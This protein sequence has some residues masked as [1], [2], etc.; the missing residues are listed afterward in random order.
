MATAFANGGE[1]QVL[2][3]QCDCEGSRFAVSISNLAAE[4]CELAADAEWP[5]ATD[6]VRLQIDDSIVMNGKLVW[7]QGRRAQMRFFGQVHPAAIA[8]LHGQAAT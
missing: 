8:R 5:G 6:F 3:G 1:A 4:G 2:D 7:V